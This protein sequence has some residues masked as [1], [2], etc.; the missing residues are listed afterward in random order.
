VD[1]DAV[2]LDE[3]A[4]DLGLDRALGA[5]L[6]QERQRDSGSATQRRMSERNDELRRQLGTLWRIAQ[7]GLGTVRDVAVYSSRAGRLRLDLALLQRER[8][9]LQRELG[10]QL[11]VLIGDG[12]LDVPQP[13]R[14][15]C[16]RLRAV[17]AR[18]RQSAVRLHDNAFGA[19]QGFEPEAAEDYD[20]GAAETVDAADEMVLEEDFVK[21][22]GAPAKIAQKQPPPPKRRPRK[23]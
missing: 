3:Q 15:T 14:E 11:A 12:R 4:V 21:R 22:R 7:S 18:M 2:Q 23:K 19:P 6:G 5:E 10:Q 13:L 20:Y 8:D 9:E 16:G 17:E 1:E